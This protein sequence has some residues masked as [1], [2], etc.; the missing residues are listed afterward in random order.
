MKPLVLVLF[1][2]LIGGIVNAQASP[3]TFDFD[4]NGNGF[5]DLENGAGFKP[6]TGVML[7]D[8]TQAGHP[9]VLTYLL[10]VPVVAGDIRVWD[11]TAHTTLSDVLRFTDA[12]GDLTGL[13]ADRLIF[14]SADGPGGPNLADSGLPSVLFANDGG[15][16]PTEDASG[17]FTWAPGGP[18]DNIFNGISGVSAVP[19]PGTLGLLTLSAGI[20]AAIRRRSR[21]E[22]K[23]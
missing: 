18:T 7:P 23:Q 15:F 14:Y 16:G 13:T 11:D 3:F 1:L 21:E 6:S 2:V 10:P 17:N 9:M 19:E 5:L 8:P 20:W 12:N 22:N 4:E